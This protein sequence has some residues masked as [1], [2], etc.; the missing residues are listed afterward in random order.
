[1]VLEDLAR[2]E[3]HV[4]PQ[5]RSTPQVALVLGSGLGSLADQFADRHAL[6]YA[7]IPGMAE[8]GVV[9]HKGQLVMGTLEGVPVIAMQGRLHPYEGH[10]LETVVLGVRLML[11]LGAS[12]L[13][14]SNAAG[15]LD[16]TL[17]P[18]TLL[19]IEDHLN[20]T[21][22]N[23][24]VGPNPSELGP[25]FPDMSQVYDRELIAVA[26]EV[27]KSQGGKL[28]QGVYA[29]VLGPSYETAAEVRMLRLLGVSAVGM[30]TVQEVIAAR[31]MGARVLG[32][33]C[34]TN[35]A[36]G[37]SPTPLTHAEVEQTARASASELTRLVC[38]IVARLRR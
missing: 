11:R 2:A 17:A 30:S 14:V 7:S 1:M 16:P 33:S 5:L 13:I 31:H 35:L 12:V 37:L 38:G 25:R 4:R 21:G 32:L 27:A 28:A 9:G 23:C 19:I 3:A 20:L 29:G 15:G 18:G 34:I 22:Q 6:P 8:T 24:L 36:S 10:S 26:H